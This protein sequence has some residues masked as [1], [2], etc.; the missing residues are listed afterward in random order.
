MEQFVLSEDGSRVAVNLMWLQ[1]LQSRVL[2]SSGSICQPQ[3][4]QDPKRVGLVLEWLYADAFNDALTAIVPFMAQSTLFSNSST[5]QQT[6]Q[7]VLNQLVQCLQQ[8]AQ[9]TVQL[10][11]RWHRM[12][13]LQQRV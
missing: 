5:A 3:P 1:K 9:L 11:Q 6:S 13:C 10:D 8:Q 12:C 4:G 2:D 7:Q